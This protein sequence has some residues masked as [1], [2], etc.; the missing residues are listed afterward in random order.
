LPY[1]IVLLRA[2]RRLLAGLW[3]CPVT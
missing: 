1:N 3:D 2:N